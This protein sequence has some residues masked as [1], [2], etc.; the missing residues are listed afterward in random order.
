MATENLDKLFSTPVFHVD[1]PPIAQELIKMQWQGAEKY[2]E[3]NLSETTWGDNI[4]T[5]FISG[6]NDAIEKYE[7]FGLA[8]FTNS[9][10]KY[11]NDLLYADSNIYMFESWINYQ[12]KHQHQ[13]QH[14]HQGTRISAVYYLKSN[15]EDGSLTFHPPSISM[16]VAD[17]SCDEWNYSMVKYPPVQGRL[18]VFPSWAPHSV[19][20]N[21]TDD[22]RISIAM[23]FR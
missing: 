2:V 11:Y 20:D 19:G 22:T 14:S 21:M 8:E 17:P 10:V 13:R 7:L 3:E 15:G 4:S 18:F 5:T 1:L 16:E 9:V 6:K 12:R 23:N